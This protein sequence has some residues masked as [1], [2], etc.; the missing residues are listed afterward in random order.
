MFYTRS[1]LARAAER[2]GWNLDS[3]LA[4]LGQ[5]YDTGAKRTTRA[6]CAATV[7]RRVF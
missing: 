4:R 3:E 2:Y 6:G 1:E 5:I 7:W